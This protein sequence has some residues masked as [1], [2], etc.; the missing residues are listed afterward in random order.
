MIMCFFV[1]AL[2]FFFFT[3]SECY[4]GSLVARC[5]KEM[6]ILQTINESCSLLHFINKYFRR[7]KKSPARRSSLVHTLYDE[8]F[9]LKMVKQH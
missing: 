7:E 1:V 9:L 3:L 5:L 6:S 8:I 2:F 4:L